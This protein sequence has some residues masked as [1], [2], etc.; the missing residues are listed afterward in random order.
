ME[1]SLVPHS[2]QSLPSSVT[3]SLAASA[4]RVDSFSDC[5]VRPLF[6]SPRS[7]CTTNLTTPSL[8]GGSGSR[9]STTP[10]TSSSE[11]DTDSSELASKVI[12]EIDAHLEDMRSESSVNEGE[13]IHDNLADLMIAE[14]DAEIQESRS[15]SDDRGQLTAQSP[16]EDESAEFDLPNCTLPEAKRRLQAFEDSYHYQAYVKD[17]C[18]HKRYAESQPRLL[19]LRAEG[20]IA[21]FEGSEEYKQYLGALG[22]VLRYGDEVDV[23]TACE[24]EV[25]SEK[26]SKIIAEKKAK[27]R[28]KGRLS[29]CWNNLGAKE[30]P[31]A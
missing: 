28:V 13:T 19:L 10:E 8:T 29:A 25:V 21:A 27:V 26:R 17:L 3:M 9:A 6:S 23:A 31:R 30:K 14:I 7:V 11:D 22:V 2:R 16:D 18:F 1:E 20:R 24:K 15:Q 4:T 12:D 5:E